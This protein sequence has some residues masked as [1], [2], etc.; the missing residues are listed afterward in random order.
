MRALVTT[1]ADPSR[2]ATKRQSK[3][4]CRNSSVIAVVRRPDSTCETSTLHVEVAHI[5]R[6]ITQ[7]HASISLCIAA[8]EASSASAHLFTASM[9]EFV[10]SVADIYLGHQLSEF[11]SVLQLTESSPGWPFLGAR[12]RAHGDYSADADL[13]LHVE[14][15]SA[16]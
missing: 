12:S 4:R 10:F 7:S 5:S 8:C 14:A 11:V 2:I 15:C 6:P 3:F 16:K 9:L 1:K 13:A